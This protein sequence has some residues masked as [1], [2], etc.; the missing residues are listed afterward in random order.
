MPIYDTGGCGMSNLTWLMDSRASL[1]AKWE[2][3]FTNNL[4][5]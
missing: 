3:R 5:E 1:G 4:A 2:R